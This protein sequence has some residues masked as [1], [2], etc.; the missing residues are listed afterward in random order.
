MLN[1]FLNL[2]VVS[3]VDDSLRIL[4]S[5]SRSFLSLSVVATAHQLTLETLDAVPSLLLH[6]VPLYDNIVLIGDGQKTPSSRNH[7]VKVYLVSAYSV[8]PFLDAFSQQ[9]KASGKSCGRYD[10]LR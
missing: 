4:K 7:L 2:D 9:R 1:Q 10:R 6:D 5:K 3:C 8:F